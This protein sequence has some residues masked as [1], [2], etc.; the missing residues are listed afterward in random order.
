M[1]GS[2]PNV[3]FIMSDDHTSQ[4]VGAYNSRLAELDP[5]PNIDRLFREG[6]VFDNTFCTNAICTPSRASILTGQYSQTNGVLDLY[7]GLPAERQHLPREFSEAG[8]TTAQFGKWHLR[9]APDAFD[10]YYTLPGQGKYFD[11]DLYSNQEGTPTDY[12]FDSQLT[13]NV[14]LIENEGHSTDVITDRML[15]WLEEDRP[16]DKPF[17]CCLHYKAP[18]DMFDHHPRYDAYLEDVEIPEP[19]NLY[20]Q[21]ATGFGSIATRGENDELIHVIGASISKRNHK[22]NMGMH[23]EVDPETEDQEYTHL[24]YQRYLKKYLRC[25]K[26]IDDNVKR[27]FDALEEQGLMDNTIIVYTGDQGMFLGEHDFMDKRWIY[28]EAMRMPFL[29]RYPKGGQA[30][31]RNDWLIDNS[32]FAPT[33][34]EMTGIPIPDY[35]QGRS[36]AGAMSG[37]A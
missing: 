33:L 18:H 6:V 32:D 8:Y 34:L 5:T 1:A 15:H 4:A 10:Y 14:N 35:M 19:D 29:V 3:L 27:V 25:V 23:M 36:F 28:E 7:D 20:N 31:V 37:E 22:R 26:G 12:R 9:T 17:F 11:P 21:P 30:G 24:A 13:M 2:K 16:K